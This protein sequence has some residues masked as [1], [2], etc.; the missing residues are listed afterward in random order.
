MWLVVALALSITLDL[1]RSPL[2]P[3]PGVVTLLLLPGAAVLVALQT[4]PAKPA[5]RL[6]LAVSLSMVAIMVVGGLASL[7]GPPLG[8]AHPL[9]ALPEWIFWALLAVIGLLICALKHSDPVTW[10][11][12]GV[13]VRHIYFVLASGLFVVLSVLGVARLNEA[14]NNHLAVLAMAAAVIALLVGVV[15][16]WSRSSRWP[17][18][19]LL[20]GASLSLLLSTSLRGAH[21]YGWDIQKEYGVASRTLSAGVWVIPANHDPFASMLSLT[22]LPAILHSLTGLYLLAFFQLVVPAILALL[23]VAVLCAANGVPRWVNRSRRVAPRPGLALAVVTGLIISSVAFSSLLVS[24]TRQAMALTIVAAIVM[25][26]FDR[27]MAIRPSRI[28]I[29]ILVVSVSFTHY[30]TSYLLTGALLVAWGVGFVW[31]LRWLRTK[32]AA[33]PQLRHVRSR[34]VINTALVV[35]SLTSALGWNLAITRN[36]ALSNASNAFTVEGAKIGVNAANGSGLPAPEFERV[37]IKE[38]AVIDPWIISYPNSTSVHLTTRVPPP[39]NGWFHGLSALWNHLNFLVDEGLWVIL[40]LSLLYGLLRL[41]RRQSDLFSADLLG[42]GVAGLVV[43]A[44]SRFS[45]TLAALYTPE[46]SA[47]VVAILMAVPVTMALDDLAST[48]A[49]RSKP[50]RTVSISA[51]LGL[52]AVYVLWATGLGTL[53]FGGYPPGS[54]TGKGLN[55][56]Q[57][58]VST[59]EYATAKW[60]LVHTNSHDIVQTDLFGQLVLLSVP[61]KYALV[62]EIVPPGSNVGSFIYLSTPNLVFHNSQAET[63]DGSYYTQYRTPIAFF[64]EQYSVV[65]STGST[66]VYR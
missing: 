55:A 62:S 59:T 19:A 66:R 24:I 39:Y 11:F 52:V 38:L 8:L 42:L 34:R 50:I 1:S 6:V 15:G 51:G 23:P 37:M 22:V 45:G 41:G 31:S 53:I 44:L 35:I 60:I 58:T 20:Y 25:V 5:G 28:V 13:Q 3:L 2:R 40:G 21:L 26:V 9:D 57:F 12:Q 47:I 49:V 54:L 64:N 16:G 14:G 10:I 36:N 29:G 48:L 32:R 4:R 18:N 33:R 17:L 7:F 43:G 27:T 63:P 30:S 61:G 65:Y 46:R 56:Q